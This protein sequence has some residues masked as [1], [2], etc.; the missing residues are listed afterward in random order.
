MKL[1]QNW[2][3]YAALALFAL[4]TAVVVLWPVPDP[5]PAVTL[6]PAPNEPDAD[7]PSDE[8][9]RPPPAGYEDMLEYVVQEGDTWEGIARL[10]VIRKETIQ[11]VNHEDGLNEPSP[12]ER[13]WIPPSE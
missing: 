12:G 7:L 5:T 13:I 10:F 11:R 1:L 2:K 4:F 9:S 8:P 6:S 3:W